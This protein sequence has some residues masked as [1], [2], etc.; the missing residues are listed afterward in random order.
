MRAL[1][2]NLAGQSARLAVQQAQLA[3]LSIAWERIEATTPA[4]LSRPA[5]DPYWST[6]ERPLRDT[7]KAVL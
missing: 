4:S 1:V 3:R 6:W 5:D 7:E 2:L